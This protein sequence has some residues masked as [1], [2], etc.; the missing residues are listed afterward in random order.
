VAIII[1]ELGSM[2]E[3]GR[4]INRGEGIKRF[5]MGRGRGKGGRTF[6]RIFRQR[7]DRLK[8]RSVS[9]RPEKEG[10]GGRSVERQR[11]RGRFKMTLTRP[12]G[13]TCG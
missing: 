10:K 7:R 2:N 9:T 4:L 6:L 8:S 1:D 3:S 5:L 12:K 13:E 11:G